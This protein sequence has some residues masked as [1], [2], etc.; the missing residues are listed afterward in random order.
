M[1]DPISDLLIHARSRIKSG[2]CQNQLAKDADGNV[3]S[4][5]SKTSVFWCIE[6]A[7]RAVDN[8]GWC[9]E[10]ALGEITAA[11]IA[12]GFELPPKKISIINAW[13]DDK[14]RSK[15]NVIELLDNILKTRRVTI[16]DN[17][18]GTVVFFEDALQ[19][20]RDKINGR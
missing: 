7:V 10:R 1:I 4:L 18:S 15:E 3:I 9:A 5:N 6:G 17:E 8:N 16:E 2:W 12:T 14:S 13:N 20:I 19:D 11:I